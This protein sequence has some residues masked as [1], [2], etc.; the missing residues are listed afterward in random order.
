MSK[1]LKL[2]NRKNEAVT[3]NFLNFM[4][5][6][7]QNPVIFFPQNFVVVISPLF[8]FLLLCTWLAAWLVITSLA[9]G[10]VGL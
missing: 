5:G 1:K 10:L 4:T 7:Q 2:H 6:R 3:T 9:S 8:S